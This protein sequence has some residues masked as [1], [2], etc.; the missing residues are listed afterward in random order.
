MDVCFPGDLWDVSGEAPGRSLDEWL[1]GWWCLSPKE[2]Q[3]TVTKC[4][5]A[6]AVSN[7]D[8]SGGWGVTSCTHTSG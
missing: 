5:G 8:L 4:R 7:L 6:G 2:D 3:K 1:G